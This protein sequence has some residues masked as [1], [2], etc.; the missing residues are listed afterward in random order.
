[1]TSQRPQPYT[2]SMA[3]SPTGAIF[4]PHT[5]KTSIETGE[6]NRSNFL[7]ALVD[8]DGIVWRA[9]EASGIKTSTYQTWRTKH[10]G[11]RAKVDNIKRHIHD[12]ENPHNELIPKDF[13]G[14]RKRY[15][16]FESPDFHLEIIDALEHGKEGSVTLI[17]IPPE[18]GKTTLLTDFCCKKLDNDRN[19]RITIG[20]EKQTHGKKIIGRIKQRM[21]PSSGPA[22]WLQECGPFAPQ[23]GERGQTWAEDRMNVHGKGGDEQDYSVIA[24]GIMSSVVGSRAD[25]LLVDD[26]QSR[27]SLAQSQEIFNNLRQD[28]LSR[29]GAFGRVVIIGTRVGPGDVYEL[30]M[31]SPLVNKVIEIPAYD[32]HTEVWDPP[33]GANPKED[34]EQI[35][36]HIT[37]FLWPERYNALNYLVMRV[38]AGEEAWDR[39]YMQKGEAAGAQ[40]FTTEVIAKAARAEF[41]VRNLQRCARYPGELAGLVDPGFGVNATMIMLMTHQWCMPVLWRKDL[42]LS[43]N[44]QIWQ[45]LE[46]SIYLG[47]ATGSRCTE[48][49]IE[50]KA[51]QKGLL[52]DPG[53]LALRKQFG[54][55]VYGHQ[56]GL[57]KYDP[58]LGIP[59][60]PRA[61][62][63]GEILLPDSPDPETT[64]ARKLLD[65]ELKKW[66]PYKRGNRLTQDLV[67]TLWFGWMTWRRVRHLLEQGG[68]AHQGWQA[69]G[70]PSTMRTTPSG[71]ALPTG[72]YG[73]RTSA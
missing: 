54:F 48:V 67:I 31:E 20:S 60:M 39:N 14:Y 13:A 52:D 47:M 41:S 15:F 42:D 38:N 24:Q 73:L 63:R 17:L 33:T 7:A 30:L 8:N 45:I 19:F 49:V 26:I 36:H 4:S 44:Q 66:R 3:E 32:G 2:G 21:E 10:P 23:P 37:S 69:T 68:R 22:L 6:R 59:Q 62:D 55:S 64:E 57:N 51:F 70:L 25:L 43:N 27:K 5:T 65:R 29:S 9:L 34:P 46:E 1:M 12:Q 71:L 50:D 35:P 18:H 11:F 28:W 56:T 40:P 16:S 61:I 58:D 72:A 53:L